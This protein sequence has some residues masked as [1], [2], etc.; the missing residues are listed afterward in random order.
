MHTEGRYKNLQA[1]TFLAKHVIADS[2]TLKDTVIKS[3]VMMAGATVKQL[4]E[5]QRNTNAFNDTM[6][7]KLISLDET[8]QRTKN[9]VIMPSPMFKLPLLD[10]IDTEKLPNQHAVMCFDNS[11][12]V[13]YICK[14]HNV[15]NHYTLPVYEPYL[16]LNLNVNESEELSV[17]MTII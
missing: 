6:K 17:N 13:I 11:G 1:D 10:E 2:I 5:S 16:R 14:F 4:Y 9:N 12:A 3:D 15:V 7:S 8:V